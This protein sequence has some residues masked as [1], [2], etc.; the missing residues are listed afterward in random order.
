MGDVILTTSFLRQ[1]HNKY[2]DASIDFATALPFAEILKYNPRINRIF[3]YDKSA[4]QKEIIEQRNNFI[5][6]GGFEKYDLAI[7]LQKN[8]RSKMLLSGISKNNLYYKKRR[9]HKLSLV[10]RKKPL[11]PVMPIPELYRMAAEAAGVEDDGSGLEIWLPGESGLDS[12]PPFEKNSVPDKIRIAMAPG[13]KHI[14]KRWPSEKFA[15]LA[16]ML[17]EEKDAEIILLGGKEDK[18][19]CGYIADKCGGKAKD[20]CGKTNILE[21]ARI[22]DRC[23]LLITNDSGVMHIAAARQTPVAAIFGSTVPAFGFGPFR[24]Q[25]EIIEKPVVCRPCTHIGRAE[26]PKKHFDCMKLISVSDVLKAV[27]RHINK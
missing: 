8:L 24:V 25:H 22:I 20:H 13:A 4:A 15:E 14:T 10:Y 12:Y 5:R 6:E 9:L 3:E 7:D 23:S 11:G 21:T 19:I 17:I 16:N 1:L 27:E 26:C 2:R 18:E